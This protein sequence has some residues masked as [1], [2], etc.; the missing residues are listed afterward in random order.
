MTLISEMKS[1]MEATAQNSESTNHDNSKKVCFKMQLVFKKM[2][3]PAKQ[4]QFCIKNIALSDLLSCNFVA[5]L[6]IV[7][8]FLFAGS[9]VYLKSVN[10]CIHIGK[11][12]CLFTLEWR[13]RSSLS[14]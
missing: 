9:E 8:S 12:Q 6:S 2:S 10:C 3:N 5:S 4:F 11:M 1:L 14:S 7:G 13:V